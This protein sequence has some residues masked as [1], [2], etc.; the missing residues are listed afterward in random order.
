[1]KSVTV[2][3]S[4]TSIPNSAFNNCYGLTE[5]IIPSGVTSLGNSAISGLNITSLTIPNSVTSIGNMCLYNM[6]KLT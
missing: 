5:F 3:A 4:L 1:L 2:P 6:K